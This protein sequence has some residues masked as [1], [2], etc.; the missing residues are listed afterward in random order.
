MQV[1]FY[2]HIAFLFFLISCCS[3]SYVNRYLKMIE[4]GLSEEIGPCD[5]FFRHVCPMDDKPYLMKVL[6]DEYIS[7]LL[8]YTKTYEPKYMK[9][10]SDVRKH[11]LTAKFQVS[12]NFTNIIS[13]NLKTICETNRAEFNSYLKKLENFWDKPCIGSTC[14]SQ[15]SEI[16]DCDRA[17]DFVKNAFSGIYP[18]D[19]FAGLVEKK[20][21]EFILAHQ[22]LRN[23]EWYD[24]HRGSY[25]KFNET[26]QEI[27][28]ISSKLLEDTPWV[29]RLNLTNIFVPYFE[30]LH[31][32]K[33]EL[34]RDNIIKYLDGFI[35]K[36]DKCME[37]NAFPEIFSALCYANV[38]REVET[39]DLWITWNAGFQALNMHPGMVFSNIVVL[40]SQIN[41]PSFYIGSV[42]KVVA[43]EI[44]HSLIISK[45]Q[46]FIPY[47][48]NETTKC[49]QNQFEKSCEYFQEGKCDTIYSRYDDNGADLFASFIISEL[50]NSHFGA[51]KNNL[52][53][54]TTKNITNA[55]L[56]FMASATVLCEKVP[57]VT[58]DL[59]HHA[60][61]VRINSIMSQNADFKE[62]FNCPDN[63]KMM[64]AKNEQCHIIGKDAPI[65]R[66]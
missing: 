33:P 42:G 16:E 31:I 14:V 59:E 48:S 6:T 66:F 60:N 37:D 13:S 40:L 18:S 28:E 64:L 47:Y 4:N 58:Q 17:L 53:E 26:A 1:N 46:D 9:I 20:I 63:S 32:Y 62:A 39:L 29:N 44:G 41:L 2:F 3:S 7:D 34:F 55:Q 25:Q 24:E 45:N 57:S 5:N 43:H 27:I 10:N 49:V 15:I 22:V 50:L 23:Y 38:L 51:D 54:G 56:A 11:F 19:E 65:S 8:N 21:R 35:G 30:Q 12:N 61:V 52:V 36:Y